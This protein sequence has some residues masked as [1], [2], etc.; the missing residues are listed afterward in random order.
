MKAF[1]L[2]DGPADAATGHLVVVA[3]RFSGFRRDDRVKTVS[4]LSAM[5]AS[6]VQR[7]PPADL[8]KP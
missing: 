7:K 8:T 3:D 1:H 4:A 2:A 6:L 5:I